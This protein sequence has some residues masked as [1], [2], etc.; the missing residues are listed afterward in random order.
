[1]VELMNLSSNTVIVT[2]LMICID[3]QSDGE[4]CQSKIVKAF[5]VLLA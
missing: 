3:L 1:M 2:M 4:K 5:L